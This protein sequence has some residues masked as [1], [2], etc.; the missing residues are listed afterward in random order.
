GAASGAGKNFHGRYNRQDYDQMYR[1]AD[2]KFRAAVE[3]GAWLK[4]MARMHD[5]LGNVTDTTRTGFNVN[6]NVGGSTVTITYST[7]FQLGDGQE[8]FVWLKS[9]HELRLLNYNLRS[10]ALDESNVQ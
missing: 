8:E 6:Y 2:P 10:R 1:E 4:L 7:K 5:K 3:P 9:N